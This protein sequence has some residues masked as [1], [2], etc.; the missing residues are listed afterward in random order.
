MTDSATL[1]DPKQTQLILDTIP[2]L[3]FLKDNANRILD[4]NQAVLDALNLKREDVVGKNTA[5]LFPEQAEQFYADDLAVLATGEPKLGCTEPLGSIWI[6][7]DK[8]PVANKAGQFDR[9]LAIATDISALK[10]SEMELAK[11]NSILLNRAREA[12][13]AMRSAE[14]SRRELQATNRRLAESESKHR[15]LY[16]DSPVMHANVDPASGLIKNC[17]QLLVDRLG[18][19]SKEQVVGSP[20]FDMYHESCHQE[21]KQ[22]FQQFVSTGKVENVELTLQQV[23]GGKV[24]VILNVASVRDSDGA[25]LYSSS[26]WSDISDLKRYTTEL[27]RANSD[28]EEFAY[29]ASH[30]LKAPLRAIDHLSRWLQEDLADTATARSAKHLKQLRQRVER[31]EALLDDLLAYSR[32]GR[33]RGE[34][35]ILRLDE[36]MDELVSLNFPNGLPPGFTLQRD[37]DVKQIEACHAPLET[38]FRNLVTNAVKHHDRPQGEIVVQSRDAG[39][40]VRFCVSDDGPGIDSDMREKALT[41]FQTLKPR[42]EVEGSGMGLAMAK[43][44]V[45]SEGG[46]MELTQ[47]EP[48]GL[49]VH[50]TWPKVPRK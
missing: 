27:E 13:Q 7:T 35:A 3:V 46:Q 10:H 42:D 22:A 28:L 17:N 12:E 36:L 15:T 50:F 39:S 19:S 14:K 24:P 30:D 21:V 38:V 48:R 43:K 47:N 26:T 2:A 18:F 40:H 45:N 23:D 4:V 1:R 5:E 20:I 16:E 6:Q 9:I 49:C 34:I 33:Q 29:V 25:V 8:I 44:L 41:M 37:F 31:M 11:A 32:A